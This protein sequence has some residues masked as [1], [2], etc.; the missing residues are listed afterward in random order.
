[1][2][3]D[4]RETLIERIE[5]IRDRWRALAADVGEARMEL[6]GAMGDWTFKD[7]AA[8]LT[9]WRRR[10]VDRLEAAGR[11]EP[12]PAPRWPASLGETEDHPIN[13]WI[14]D[15]TKDQPLADVLADTET[16]YDDFIAA[17]RTIPVEDATDPNHF[18]WLE[19]VSLVDSDFGGHLTEHEPDVRGWLANL[20][21]AS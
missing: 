15:E 4:P 8:H 13:A 20:D 7:V 3:D 11:G 17:I 19:G 9:A 18:E 1:M 12:A 14:H 6:P 2:A 5:A 21:R 16:T 10:T